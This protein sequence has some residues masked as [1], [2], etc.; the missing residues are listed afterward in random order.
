LH[1]CGSTRFSK[2]L[3]FFFD[4]GANESPGDLLG[5]RASLLGHDRVKPRTHDV[6]FVFDAQSLVATLVPLRKCDH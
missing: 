3:K 4:G 5:A 1:V 2:T 6:T